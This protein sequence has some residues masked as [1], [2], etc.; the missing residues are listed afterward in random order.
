[1]PMT[2]LR[3]KQSLIYDK[4][5]EFRDNQH[6]VEYVAYAVTKADVVQLGKIGAQS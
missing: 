3:P 2:F 4:V 1:M 6:G 5:H